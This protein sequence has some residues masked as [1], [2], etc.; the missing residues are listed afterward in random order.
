MMK[1][2]II[3][4]GKAGASLAIILN[5][6]PNVELGAICDCN[7]TQLS[8]LYDKI[9]AEDFVTSTESLPKA[10]INLILTPDDLIINTCNE[11]SKSMSSGKSTIFAHCSGALPSSALR[12]VNNN[13]QLVA[14]IHPIKSFAEPEKAAETF[15]GTFCGFEGDELAVNKLKDVFKQSGANCFDIDPSKK[16]LYHAAAVLSCNYL[17]T[18]IEIGISTYEKAG[19][20]RDIATRIIETISKDTLNNV[21]L[22]SPADA[23]TGPI[24][25]GDIATISKHLEALSIEND[26]HLLTVYKMLGLETVSLSENQGMANPDDL[27]AIKNLLRL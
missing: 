9:K 21:F 15:A 18:L 7:S 25:R 2:N 17:N 3:G 16:A 12:D 1:I 5:K 8:I 23:L 22:S 27:N 4:A 14:S 11:I 6:N 19:V 10:D 26:K 20:N 13:I 24:S